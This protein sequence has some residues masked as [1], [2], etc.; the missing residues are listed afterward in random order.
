MK[1]LI[2][3]GPTR[4]PLDPVRYLTNRS[5]GK[6]GYALAEAAARRGH[7]VT[8]VSGPT[9][10]DVPVKVDY[11]PVET[12]REMFEAVRLQIGKSDAAIFTAAVADYRPAVFADKKIKKSG[13]S[14]TLELIRN[15]DILG[16]A[17]SEFGF[18]GILV[19]FA[20]ETENLEKNARDKL[21]RK[22]CN[23]V[24]ANDVSQSGIGFDSDHNQVLL[25]YP[26][27]VEPLPMDTKEHVAHLILDSIVEL[28]NMSD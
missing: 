25:V 28:Q 7:R 22:G 23:L 17:R 4:E 6:M 3:A 5:S 19:G 13:E 14:M 2:T 11:I 10:L 18:Q 21:E 9:N 16:S 26:G 1:I 20:A 8:L 15:A 24:V 27:R 12:A